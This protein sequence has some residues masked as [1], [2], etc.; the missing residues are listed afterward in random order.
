[1]NTRNTWLEYNESEARAQLRAM[2]E[3]GDTMA[4]RILERIA[5]GRV[6]WARD[7]VESLADRG[8]P[9][10]FDHADL[11]M[12]P[13][14]GER[15]EEMALQEAA[16]IAALDALDASLDAAEAAYV[17]ELAAWQGRKPEALL[18]SDAAHAYVRHGNGGDVGVFM[19]AAIARAVESDVA[20]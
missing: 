3:S 11:G 10:A 16:R 8:E 2:S 13:V 12:V 14:T 9:W 4:A 18:P 1:M 7:A 15:A 19:R 6:Q 17:A 20:E 5:D